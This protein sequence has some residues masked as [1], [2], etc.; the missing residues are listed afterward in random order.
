MG[1]PAGA[2]VWG[3]QVSVTGLEFSFTQAPPSHKSAVLALFFL[4]TTAGN[5]LDAVVT[6]LN[7]LG[8]TAQ[9]L[10]FAALMLAVSGVF[11]LS[12]AAYRSRDFSV[13]G[14]HAHAGGREVQMKQRQSDRGQDEL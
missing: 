11:M 14:V 13:Q 12:A 8:G 6:A 7:V 5:V 10:A 1:Q 2:E 3:V 4:T 9:F